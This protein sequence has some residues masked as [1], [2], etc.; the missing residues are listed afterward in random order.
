[1]SREILDRVWFA[2]GIRLIGDGVP[3][4]DVM[5]AQAGLTH[6]DQWFPYWTGR[7]ETYEK[8][9]REALDRGRRQSAGEL[10][11]QACLSHHYA[12][13]LWF[14]DS[15]RR[16]A[17]QNRK[18]A[19]YR[20]AAP[21]FTPPAE[22]FDLPFEGFVIPGYLRLPPGASGRVPVAM[23]L[24]GLESTKEESYRFE[25]LCLARGLATC[26]FDG[27]GQGEM[28]FQAKLRPDFHRFAS[29][30]VDWLE[31]QPQI[32]AGRIGVIGRSL[33]GFYAIHCAAHDP[34]FKACAGACCSICRI[35]TRCTIRPGAALPSWRAMTIPT[36]LRPIFS[37][38][39]TCQA[40]PSAY[41]ARSMHC[42]ARRMS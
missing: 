15:V 21:L 9:A 29:A 19:L 20:E 32:D 42:M 27:P 22:R 33:G 39:S 37:T 40:R 2:S 6:W 1:M 35:T 41:A 16:D 36:R 18:V 5:A 14:H 3:A 17:G 12:Q 24:G 10:F 11:W 30:G 31:K 13:F 28:Y 8:L 23:I 38:R 26:A 7:G 34:R 25:N 4:G